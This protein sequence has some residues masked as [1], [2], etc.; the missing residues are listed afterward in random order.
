MAPDNDPE[1]PNS[2]ASGGGN[3]GRGGFGKAAIAVIVV[4]LVIIAG[5]AVLNFVHVPTQGSTSKVVTAADTAVTNEPYNLSINTNGKFK[6]MTIHYGDGSDS[7][8]MYT[9]STNISVSHVYKNPGE[10]YIY[11][12]VNFGST[13]FMGSGSLVNVVATNPAPSQYTSLGLITMIPGQSS[14]PIISQKTVFSPGSHASF[15]LGYY[16]APSNSSFSVIGQT[17]TVF[18]NGT[19]VDQVPL[20]YQFNSSAGAY[21]LPQSGAEYNISSLNQGYYELLINTYTAEISNST[22]GSIS[23]TTGIYSTSYYLDVPVFPSA[24]LFKSATSKSVYVDAE[25]SPGGYT[26]LDPAIAYDLMGTDVIANTL[27]FLVT[28]NMTSPPNVL[29]ALITAL[30]TVQNGMVN[31]NSKNYT[32]T[33][34]WGTTYTATLKPYENF[35]YK[36]RANAS[37]QDGTPVTAWDVMYAIT[38]DLLFDAGSPGTPGWILAQYLLPGDIYSSNTFYNITQNITVNNASNS[39]TFHFQVPMSSALVNELFA[40]PGAGSISSKWLA[41]H[42]SAITWTPKGFQDYKSQGLSSNYNS[43]VQNNVFSDGPYKVSYVIPAS[44]VVLVANPYF[45][46]PGPWYPK[47]QINEIIINYISE[48]STAYLAVKAGQAQGTSIPTSNWNYVQSLNASG[49]AKPYSY[50]SMGLYFYSFNANVNTTVMN[51]VMTGGN[52]PNN[53]FVDLAIRKAFAYSYNYN[54]YLDYQIGNKLYNTIF[55]QKFAGALPQGMLYAQTIAELN[56]SG[57]KVPYYSPTIAKQYW[58][59]FLNSTDNSILNI[60]MSGGK[61]YY[62]GHPLVVP[63]FLYPGDPADAAGA[64]TWAD[65]LMNTTGI[66]LKSVTLPF[67]QLDALGSQPTNPMALSIGI[68]FPDYPYPTD[69]LQPIALP[70]NYSAF[71]GSSDFTPYWLYGNTSNSIQN[72]TQANR[73]QGL[74]NDYNNGTASVV[75][76][77]TKY[78]FQKMN[79]EYTNLTFIVPLQQQY[80]YREVSTKINPSAMTPWEVNVMLYQYLSYT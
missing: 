55:G 52:M 30:P 29:P 9:G 39:I 40:A 28:T 71:L 67:T 43:Y 6:D 80:T 34:P 65:N 74:V 41:E 1:V 47:P 66:T 61:A 58:D 35:T 18:F 54:Y 50:P 11:F 79:E 8:V 59:N 23:S 3:S 77:Q 5:L 16:T 48:I 17:L 25:I 78:W 56:A 45:T 69:Y 7:T 2:G 75:A 36:I 20:N 24:S 10:Y 53:L 19:Q 13:T 26:S 42:G 63:V 60:S 68:W 73:L 44:Q 12:I 14:T 72:Q 31:N 70:S 33:T 21:T 46:A 4:L 51:T 76:S 64:T 37:W 57:V 22:T 32:Q 62:N 49:A 15:L 38:R 27:Q